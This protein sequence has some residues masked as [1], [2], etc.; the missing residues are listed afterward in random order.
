MTRATVLQKVRQMRFEELP[1]ATTP[2]GT[3]DGGA[4][5]A[6]GDAGSAGTRVGTG[7][8]PEPRGAN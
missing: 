7:R 4:G 6:L 2:T 3:H 1:C 5:E 8:N